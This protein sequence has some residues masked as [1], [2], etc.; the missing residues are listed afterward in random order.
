MVRACVIH[1]RNVYYI[2]ASVIADGIA[3]C[4]SVWTVL[5]LPLASAQ[6]HDNVIK[7]GLQDVVGHEGVAP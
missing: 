3:V 2:I 5:V 6:H 7:R 4:S 1:N